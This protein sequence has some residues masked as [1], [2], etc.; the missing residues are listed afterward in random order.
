MPHALEHVLQATIAQ[1][2]LWFRC[3]VQ[4]EAYRNP[5]LNLKQRVYHAPLASMQAAMEVLC[6]GLA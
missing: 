4:Q 2:A 5:G 6:A 3:H 1:K